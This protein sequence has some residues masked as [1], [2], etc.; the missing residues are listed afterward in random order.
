MRQVIYPI[1]RLFSIETTILGMLKTVLFQYNIVF[2]LRVQKPTLIL[3][4]CGDISLKIIINQRKANG[5]VNNLF[6]LFIVSHVHHQINYF[7]FFLYKNKVNQSLTRPFGLVNQAIQRRPA[8][9][10]VVTVETNH[11]SITSSTDVKF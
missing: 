9:I 6:M 8:Q 7:L 5:C 4:L 1:F 11:A 10:P 3:E 2:D